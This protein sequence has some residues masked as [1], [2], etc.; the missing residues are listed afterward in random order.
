CSASLSFVVRSAEQAKKAAEALAKAN[1][2]WAE[3]RSSVA[4]A[5]GV[6]TVAA[7]FGLVTVACPSAMIY[8][9]GIDHP[10]VQALLTILGKLPK[11]AS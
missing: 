2:F 4:K 5:S 9:L 10:A 3:Y 6:A 7:T 11:T 1:G 8:F